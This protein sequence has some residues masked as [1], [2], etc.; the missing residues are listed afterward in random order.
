MLFW[1]KNRIF[2]RIFWRNFLSDFTQ[3]AYFLKIL[4]GFLTIQDENIQIS[5]VKKNS[6]RHFDSANRRERL[7]ITL[8]AKM[9]QNDTR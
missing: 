2:Y 6:M 8:C 3:P 5:C 1:V 4:R 7:F 9:R